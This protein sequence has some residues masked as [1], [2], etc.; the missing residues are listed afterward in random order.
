M[1]FTFSEEAEI[2]VEVDPRHMTAQL[3]KTP[4]AGVNRISLGVQ[5]F[6]EKVM[7]TV[8]RVQPFDGLSGS[9][10]SARGRYPEL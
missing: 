1:N 5:D 2:A 9:S 6:D 7:T 4:T 3:A 8:G 10:V